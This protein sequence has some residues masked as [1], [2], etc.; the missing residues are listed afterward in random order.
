MDVDM[1][2]E[3]H[4]TNGKLTINFDGKVKERSYFLKL[5]QNLRTIFLKLK[6]K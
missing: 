2:N 4:V 6:T 3:T 1:S 5:G